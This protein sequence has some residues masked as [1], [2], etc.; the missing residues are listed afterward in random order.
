MRCLAVCQ[1]ELAIR[2]L[3]DILLPSF[4]VE[5][6]VESKQ[7][8]RRLHEGGLQVTAADLRRTDTYL[9]A[10]LTPG[11]CVVVE[12]NGR[13]SLRKILE[14]IWD[15]GGT[16]V[17]VLGIGVPETRKREE[18][19]KS[20]FPELNYLTLSELFGG[21]LLT[22]FSRSLTRLKVQQYQRF[23]SD[24]DRVVILLHNDPD[25]DA[26]A[27]GL[28]LRNVLRRT[29]QT[30][31]IAALQGVTR[32]ENQRMMNLLD[33][34]VEIL[35]PSQV[36]AFDRIAMVD[37][38][39]HYF[40]GAIDRVDLVI[41]H[42]PEQS[43][44]TAVYKDIRPDYGS[45]STIL[46]EHLRAI[47]VNIS[48]RTATAMLY[49]I[50]SDTLFFNRQA[51]R[52]DIDSFSYLYPLADAT[53]I[54]KMEGAEITMDRLEYVLK[55]KQ[56]GRLVEQVFCAFLGASPREDFIPY[57]ADFYLQLEDVKWTIVSGIVNDSL[58]LSVRNL[59]YGR[60]AGEF[61][62]KYFNDIGSAGGHRS[63]AKAVVPLR[64][65]REKFGNLQADQ[66]TDRV[67]ELALEF[68]HE[69]QPADKKLVKA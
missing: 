62:R 43:G 4:E 69:H 1:T 45:T 67:L 60:N 7:V 18:E 24:A 9:K 31:L 38:Q 53:L 48:E 23:F 26:M 15:A 56:H 66:F 6:L 30:A 34:H 63:M 55:A 35:T 27:S 64:A 59:G 5:F 29:K 8:A 40:G 10:D 39:P 51:N 65:F 11:T 52:V 32:P 22:E 44:Y 54:R 2:M 61:V 17:Y 25:P 57:V 37:V 58:V 42:H 68:L 41:D 19:L 16:L 36:A 49:A 50:K 28:A 21:P 20:E 14:S 12:D 46:T 13:R 3:D 47:D 33:I